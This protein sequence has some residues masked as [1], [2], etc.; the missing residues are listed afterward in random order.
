MVVMVGAE[1]GSAAFDD[2]LSV[3]GDTIALRGWSGYAGGLDVQRT[4]LW[5]D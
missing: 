5:G 4:A 3:L 2:F 1:T